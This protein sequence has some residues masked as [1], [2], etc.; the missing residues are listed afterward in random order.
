MTAPLK[1]LVL[2]FLALTLTSCQM[3]HRWRGPCSIWPM[4]LPE[5]GK[6]V[7]RDFSSAEG[8]FR[9]GLSSGG[10]AASDKKDFRWLILNVGEFHV[11]YHDYSQVVDTPE[12]SEGLLNQLRDLVVS[13]RPSGQL[14]GD[15]IITLSGHPGREIK[16]RDDTGI[17][18]DR[19][20]LAGN[21]LYV[22]SVF[23]PKDLDCKLGSAVK[24][25]DSFEIT[26]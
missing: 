18:L 23:I 20:Y 3:F 2:C 24:V 5:G 11:N 26:E 16:M 25:L 8:R 4:P 7:A 10:N 9:I 1:I 19:L 17:Q 21:R 15:S 13:K 12:V 14:E 6:P 22:V